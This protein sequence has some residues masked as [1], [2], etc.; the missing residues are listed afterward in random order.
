MSILSDRKRKI[1]QAIVEAHIAD[2]GPVG[3]KYLAQDKQLAC[4]SA[5]I[6]NEMA[7]LEAMG[8][9]EQPHTS[10]GRIP[11]ELGYRFY[12]DS[13]IERYSMTNSEIE[14]INRT[15]REKLRELDDILSDASRLASSLTNYT[16]VAIKPRPASVRVLRYEC[17]WVDPRSAVLVMLFPGG[18]VKT[19]QIRLPLDTTPDELSAVS[20]LFNA[21]LVG[22][23]SEEITLSTICQLERATGR[24]SP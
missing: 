11:S 4:S 3:S 5:T 2:G 13:L 1:L 18:V 24:L 23:T 8:Y 20:A 19:K 15:L 17:M 10:A 7:E 21:R 9:L 22:L 12:V 14:A 16:A 6:R